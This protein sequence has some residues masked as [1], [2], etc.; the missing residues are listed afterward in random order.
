MVGTTKYTD[1]QINFILDRTV[2]EIPRGE[3]NN[4]HLQAVAEFQRRYNQPDFGLNQVR[5]VT[6]RYGTDPAYGNRAA[7]IIRRQGAG[8]DFSPLQRTD[9]FLI[10]DPTMAGRKSTESTKHANPPRE[11]ACT[12]CNGSGVEPSKGIQQ[13]PSSKRRKGTSTSGTALHQAQQATATPPSRSQPP[14]AARATRLP[15][16][17]PLSNNHMMLP[18]ARQSPHSSFSDIA[19]PSYNGGGVYG[20]NNAA[21]RP[22]D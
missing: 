18:G 20:S 15:S 13:E 3:T 5:Y 22:G 17:S 1:E 16:Q 10:A 7:N 6:E 11:N 19:S 14:R 8:A 12:R 2:R 4:V 9:Q 21:P